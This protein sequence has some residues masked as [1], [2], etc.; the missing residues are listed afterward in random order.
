MTYIIKDQGKEPNRYS[1][2]FSFVNR[3]G[4]VQTICIVKD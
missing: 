3:E 4:L 2:A 1:Y